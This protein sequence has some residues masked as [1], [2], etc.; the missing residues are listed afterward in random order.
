MSWIP[1]FV[2]MTSLVI[3]NAIVLLNGDGQGERRLGRCYN[4]GKSAALLEGCVRISL[5]H[6]APETGDI[7]HNRKLIERGV[8]AAAEAGAQWAITPELCVSGYLFL[9]SIGTGWINPQPDLWMTGFQEFVRQQGITVFLSHPELDPASG[10]MYNSVFIIGPDGEITGRHRKVKT[11]GGAEAWSSPGWKISPLSCDG[12]K[13]GILVCADAYKNDVAEVLVRKGAQVLVS[14]VAWGPGGC[15]PD[16]EWEE[17]SAQ[18]GLPIIVC[19]RTGIEPRE[20]DYREAESVVAQHGRRLLEATSDRSVVL[21]F[22]W[23]M[24]TMTLQS[25]DFQRT[26]L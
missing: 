9:K 11:L 25:E 13:A 7:E 15:G 22:D 26:Y 18:T 19:N 8:V 5:L 10:R 4:R 24:E 12:V 14:P 2:G 6:I 21:T 1:A 17:R 3:S 23:D 16:G 20:L